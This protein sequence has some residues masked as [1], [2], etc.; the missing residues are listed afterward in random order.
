MQSIFFNLLLHISFTETKTL[1]NNLNLSETHKICL[2]K[3]LLVTGIDVY[4]LRTWPAKVE[5][6]EYNVNKEG[7]QTK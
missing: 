7:K 1:D 2:K 3:L 5:A 4:Y 6:C